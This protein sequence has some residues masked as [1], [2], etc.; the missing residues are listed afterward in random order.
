[1]KKLGKDSCIGVI[2][3]GTMGSGIAQLAAS[4]GHKVILFDANA[5]VLKMA[6]ERLRKSLEVLVQKGKVTDATAKSTIANIHNASLL[7]ELAKCD[8][9]IEAVMKG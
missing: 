1:M 9:V 8:L 4:F 6:D 3:A 7:D 5:T 2:G